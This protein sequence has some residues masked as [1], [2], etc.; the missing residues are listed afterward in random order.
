M[1]QPSAL[2]FS[3]LPRC[4][5]NTK[6]KTLIEYKITDVHKQEVSYSAAKGNEYNL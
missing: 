4:N 2:Q 5:C 3:R 1:N 6:D